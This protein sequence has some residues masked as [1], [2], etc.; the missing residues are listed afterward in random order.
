MTFAELA[1]IF[2]LSF[3]FAIPAVL[4]PGPVSTIIVSQAPRHGWIVGPLVSTGHSILEFIMIALLA[5]GMAAGLNTPAIQITIA[6]LGGLLLAWMGGDMIVG[7][8][9]G[10]VRVPGVSADIENMSR[11]QLLRLGIVTTLSNPFWYAWWVTSVPTYLGQINA[12]TPVA[13]TAFYFGHISVDYTW[14]TVLSG[15][16]ASGKRWI[17]NTIYRWVIGLCGV[18]FLYLGVFFLLEGIKLIQG[19]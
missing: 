18:F 11:G 8:W 4:S 5:F 16:V 1:L 3:T 19:S 12:V 13:I 15:V 17:T 9:K 2:G 7:A 14:N 10:K 6:V